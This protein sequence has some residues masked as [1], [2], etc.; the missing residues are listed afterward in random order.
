MTLWG[1]LVAEL[2]RW[3]AA[4]RG[5][6]LWWRDDDA[7]S[8]TPALGR[9][10]ELRARHA[11]PLALAVIP[12]GADESL[13]RRVP[14]DAN[15]TVLQHG[16]AHRNH[17]STGEP[18]CELAGARPLWDAASELALGREH[19]L[20]LFGEAAL[21]V[22]VPPWNRIDPAMIPLLPGLGFVGLSVYHAR[23]TRNPTPGLVL[24]N[25]HVDIIDWTGTHGY[26]GDDVALT[27][28]IDHLVQ[29]RCAAVDADEATGI[30]TH[31]LAQDAGS[32]RF[33]DRFLAATSGGRI[34][35]WVSARQAFS[36]AQ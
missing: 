16:F 25:T 2:D 33:L 3:A 4:G 19:M 10:L 7:V 29:R 9:L 14:P 15:V 5:P 35:Q 30:L 28:V 34:A 12:A 17:A 6:T 21:D 1:A 20:S 13:A 24:T 22:L 23:K 8:D 32:W 31:H 36:A 11:V 26:V 27:A 18:K